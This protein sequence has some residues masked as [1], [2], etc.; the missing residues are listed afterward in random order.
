MRRL[1]GRWMTADAAPLLLEIATVEPGGTFKARALRG[2]LRIARQFVLS[3][4][5]RAAMCCKALAA[6][7]TDEGR[8]TVLEVVVR[9]PSNATL[10]VAEEAAKIPGLEASAKKA[11]STI[12]A[13]LQPVKQSG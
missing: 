7:S 11:A 9:Y 2:Y 4:E 13:K 6:V 10:G 12:K 8:K 5:E 3:D 1:L